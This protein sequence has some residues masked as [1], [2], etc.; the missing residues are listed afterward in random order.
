M[1]R[2]DDELL[3]KQMRAVSPPRDDVGLA[4]L[5]VFAAGLT[6]GAMLFAG[7]H[8]PVAPHDAMAVM[9]LSND[10]PASMNR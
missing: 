9:S 1:N 6:L 5:A 3:A 2:R 8:E 7:N 4:L 10:A